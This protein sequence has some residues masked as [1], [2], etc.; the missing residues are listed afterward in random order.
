MTIKTT[1]KI[2]KPNA[3]FESGAAAYDDKRALYSDAAKESINKNYDLLQELNVFTSPI[4]TEWDPETFTLSVHKFID[5]EQISIYWA[6][7]QLIT[8]ATSS[9]PLNGW[10]FVEII[11]LDE[12]AT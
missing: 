2:K 4:Q 6:I 8:E 11:T 7:H 10:E 1:I 5:P 12:S 3:V 9:Q